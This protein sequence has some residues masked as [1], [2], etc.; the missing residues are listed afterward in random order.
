MILAAG[1][2]TRLAP[3]TDHKPKVLY[4]V[5]EYTL[6]EITIRFLK[7]HGISEFVINVHHFADQVID[8]LEKNKGFGLA[9]QVSDE[10]EALLNT[11]GAIL[12]ARELL[13]GEDSFV[14]TGS[15][16]L[17]DLDLSAMIR[18]HRQNK[19][20]A[21]LAVKDRPTSRSLIFSEDY[22]LVGWKNNETGATRGDTTNHAR[23]ALGF[24]TIHV[25][26]HSIFDL[27]IEKG[28]FSITDLYLRLMRSQRIQ[29]YRHD[30]S[31]WIEFGRIERMNDILKSREFKRMISL[32]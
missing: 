25:I 28:A 2:G 11:G 32:V 3:F 8:Y 16:I 4:P 6:L 20:L 27:I 7:K 10:R 31:G 29:G 14:L 30:E 12:K 22:R 24:S 26:D 5:K 17:T 1:L 15:D 23:Y 18:Y 9:Y 19:N 13:A 21:T